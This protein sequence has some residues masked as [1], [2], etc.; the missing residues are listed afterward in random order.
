MRLTPEQ[1]RRVKLTPAMKVEI[2]NM[3]DQYSISAIARKYNVSRQTVQFILY[4]ERRLANVE[5][6]KAN[7][8]WKKYYNKEVHTQRVR[9]LNEYKKLLNQ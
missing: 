9:N 5:N 7:H 2:L 1:D 8:G 3:K 6:T 4:P